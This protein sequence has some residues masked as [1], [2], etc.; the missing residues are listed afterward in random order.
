MTFSPDWEV[1][2]KPMLSQKKVLTGPRTMV[3]ARQ[4]PE[5]TL[6]MNV[7][8]CPPPPKKKKKKNVCYDTEGC[9][10]V[11]ECAAK[12]VCLTRR[13]KRLLFYRGNSKM[14]ISGNIANS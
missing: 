12:Y 14:Y 9:N 1:H 6:Y 5:N 8:I 13:K 4:F 11:D 7:S 2:V 10:L 3:G